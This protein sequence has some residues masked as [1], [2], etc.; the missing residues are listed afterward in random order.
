MFEEFLAIQLKEQEIF[1]IL[2]QIVVILQ[3]KD[4]MFFFIR[5]F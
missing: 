4:K 5:K 3:K 2:Q 1:R